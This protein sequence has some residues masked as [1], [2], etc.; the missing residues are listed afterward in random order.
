MNRFFKVIP[1]IVV[2]SINSF[3]AEPSAFGAGDLNNPTPYGLTQSEK[4]VLDNKNKI[5]EVLS[6]SRN[7]EY[8]VDSLRERLD[9]LQ[10]IV[11]SLTKSSYQNKIDL[12]NL[13]EKNTKDLENSSEYEK[14]LSA[15]IQNNTNDINK[16]NLAVDS[17]SQLIQKFETIY[18]TKTEYNNLVEEFNKFKKLIS[19][20]LNSNSSSNNVVQKHHVCE[21]AL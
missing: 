17:L 13:V 3:S 8:K 18:V 10:S 1:F 21:Q 14:R 19:K 7:Q 4:A 5:Q 6:K 11:E 15:I 2:F 12:K 9:G 20:E 16:T